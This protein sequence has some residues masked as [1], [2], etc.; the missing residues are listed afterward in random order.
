[1]ERLR[2]VSANTKLRND[3]KHIA[4]NDVSKD[5]IYCAIVLF[6]GRSTVIW[7]YDPFIGRRCPPGRLPPAV[8][9]RPPRPP[10]PCVLR[11]I[12]EFYDINQ[13]TERLPGSRVIRISGCPGRKRT[14]TL[15]PAA[16]PPRR[17]RPSS[18]WVGGIQKF[19]FPDG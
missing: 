1:M 16:A 3:V 19:M 10:G 17:P 14:R 11:G 12:C 5:Y 13:C 15:G 7:P 8:G 2:N 9:R 6:S 18:G 4:V